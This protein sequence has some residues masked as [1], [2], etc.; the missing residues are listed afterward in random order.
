MAE[1]LNFVFSRSVPDQ[2]FARQSNRLLVEVKHWVGNL[3][4]DL[5]TT[6]S[7]SI[8]V[9]THLLKLENLHRRNVNGKLCPEAVAFL[10]AFG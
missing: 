5:D 9:P 8:H 6:D 3:N 2:H 4:F 1:Y 7:H 10:D